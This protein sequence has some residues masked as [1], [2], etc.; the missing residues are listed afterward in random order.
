MPPFGS[1]SDDADDAKILLLFRHYTYLF[2][3][4]KLALDTLP[5]YFSLETRDGASEIAP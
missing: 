5:I 2:I 3:G 1:H 4:C